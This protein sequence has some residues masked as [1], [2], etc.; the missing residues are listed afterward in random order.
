M[1]GKEIFFFMVFNQFLYAGIGKVLFTNT[2]VNPIFGNG[3][4]DIL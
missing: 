1:K 2:T 4:F 3:M